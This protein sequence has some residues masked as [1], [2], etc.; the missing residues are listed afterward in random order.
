MRN[1]VI[2]T[3]EAIIETIGVILIIVIATSDVMIKIIKYFLSKI[4][5][6]RII[7]QKLN[8]RKF[9]REIEQL[10][11]EAESYR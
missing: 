6:I 3:I 5:I 2:E 9:K 11:K 1:I 10:R 8:E 7:K 4:N